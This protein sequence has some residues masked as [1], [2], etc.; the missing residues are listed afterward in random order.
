MEIDEISI[1]SS[2]FDT[3]NKFNKP[4]EEDEDE[5]ENEEKELNDMELNQRI[6]HIIERVK[7]LDFSQIGEAY[8]KR[9]TRLIIE[10][11]EMNNFKSYF[12]VE[13]IGPLYHRF[14][15][16]VGPNG[17]G[18]SNLM[19]SLLFVF[20]KKARSMRL[21]RLSD[22]IH[23]SANHEDVMYARVS[24]YFKEIK[25]NS[26]HNE[27]NEAEYENAYEIIPNSEFSITREVNKS[28]HSK[29]YMNNREISHNDLCIVLD[30]YG[31]DLKHNR[32]L[33][34]QGE[35]E[36]ISL[37]PPK[38]KSVE[39]SKDNPGL[40][41]YLEDIIGTNR[42]VPFIRHLS[43]DSDEIQEIKL[44]K[45]KRVKLCKTEVLKMG[46]SK[47]ICVEYFYKEKKLY[48]MKYLEIKINEI[49]INE[50]SNSIK[51][52]IK[53]KENQKL[54]I[55]K[56]LEDLKK[57][58]DKILSQLN[59]KKIEQKQLEKRKEKEDQKMNQLDEEDKTKRMELEMINSEIKKEENLKKVIIKNYDSLNE[60]LLQAKNKLQ[61]VLDM[62]VNLESEIKNEEGKLNLLEKESY[63]KTMSLQVQKKDVERNLSPFI[64][65]IQELEYENQQKEKLIESYSLYSSLE[66]KMNEM[67]KVNN[68]IIVKQKEI[69]ELL[70]NEE[71]EK[72]KQ[73]KL[74]KKH[75]D[76]YN[77]I[78]KT[79]SEIE[80]ITDDY[81]IK[82]NSLNNERQN[83]ENK[84]KLLTSL[85]QANEN[86]ILKGIRGRMGDLGSI[87]IKYDI[88]ISS[89]SFNQL[90]NILVDT[91]QDAENCVKFLKNNNLGRA[92]F[93][94]LTQIEGIK[95][96]MNRKFICPEGTERLFD[97]IKAND[98]YLPAFYQILRNTLVAKDLQSANKAAYGNE[99]HRV[100]TLSGEII[101]KSGAMTGGGK[102]RQG[103]MS[104]RKIG[105]EGEIRKAIE[106]IKINIDKK[107]E[108]YTENMNKKHN[109]DK[110]MNVI[111]HQINTI[112]SNI[113]KLEKQLSQYQKQKL[114]NEKEIK[115]L[116]SEMKKAEEDKDKIISNKDKIQKNTKKIKDLKDKSKI[117]NDKL[118][119]I[120]SQICEMGGELLKERKE[121]LKEKKL[122]YKEVVLKKN[123]YEN[124]INNGPTEINN[125]KKDIE[126]KNTL[127][128][129][130]KQLI[131]QKINE[132]IEIEAKAEEVLCQIK[133]I[134][135]LI[136]KV[137]LEFTELGNQNVKFKESLKKINDEKNKI[138]NEVYTIKSELSKI[139]YKIGTCKEKERETR[140]KY[141]NFI[142]EFGFIEDL[143]KEIYQIENENENIKKEK[144]VDQNERIHKKSKKVKERKRSMNNKI[145]LE[146]DEDI[147]DDGEEND[148]EYEEED[149][150][151][152]EIKEYEKNKNS[153][154]RIYEHKL[155]K[156]FNES[157]FNLHIIDEDQE[158]NNKTNI[159]SQINKENSSI[160]E[161]NSNNDISDNEKEE[162]QIQINSE[163]MKELLKSKSD[164]QILISNKSTELDKLKPNMEII[165]EYKNKLVDLKSRENDLSLCQKQQVEVNLIYE[166]IK[167]KRH[168]E[169]I[170]GFNIINGKL[171]EMYRVVTN[172]GDAELELVDS[173]D[174]FTEG[175]SF[176][177]RPNKKSWKQIINLSGGEKTLSSLSLIFALHHFKPS[178]LYVMDEIDAALDFK[179]VSIIAS[180]IK[181]RTKDTQFIIIS[182]RSH[183][184][185]LANKL[186]GIYKT[187]DVTKTILFNNDMRNNDLNMKSKGK[188]KSKEKNRNIETDSKAK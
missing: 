75:E 116:K 80:K 131:Q 91:V 168:K 126:Y 173:I 137:K 97:K 188:S 82:L 170:E 139:R 95:G 81:Q 3:K 72:E 149:D 23:K 171:K 8:K 65:E 94:I 143:V 11:I 148:E 150:G 174:P 90:D 115:H 145:I 58:N 48:Y 160:V 138:D 36:Q 108:E 104:N 129:S 175:I 183:M 67:D 31:I 62:Y 24:V 165:K 70:K 55:L 96:E 152:N 42:Y 154:K 98:E 172:G 180:Y 32:F 22:L 101:E 61:S 177:V 166:D 33:I 127:I 19:E 103:A 185:E 167:R 111:T 99:R 84:S 102:P 4:H 110:E 117:L 57:K 179:N 123:E 121:E 106:E 66:A 159:N 153:K 85:L 130:K 176:S 17:S 128:E 28:S 54:F 155:E 10:R 114:D 119:M 52:R 141:N 124:I 39:L 113:V 163:E 112:S 34:L 118:Q 144:D 59:E 29:Y 133:E 69:G 40:L 77:S 107:K 47:D 87:D 6:S 25:D 76:E 146:D 135:G 92:T 2:K 9:E 16:V 134:S 38:G 68:E 120:E 151:E 169:F 157:I 147:E 20:G 1:T 46:D 45:E 140:R 164:L 44:Q 64:I 30:K 18:K 156:Y 43:K 158:N 136:D 49:E 21:K 15:A 125:I 13:S 37:L 27:G 35:V 78:L 50:E 51:L 161:N 93:M 60:N 12:G 178:P 142:G 182:L 56:E 89:S 71:S 105:N 83:K 186:I 26:N 88:A 5:A 74:G 132:Q 109:I 63:E 184:F 122:K 73:V 14:N 53:E 162:C 7:H 41:E 79:I 187:H 181:E 100:V 86:G